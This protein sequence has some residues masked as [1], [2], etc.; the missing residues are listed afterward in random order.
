MRLLIVLLL[1]CLLLYVCWPL[2]IL[3]VVAVPVVW[4]LLLPFRIAKVV[5]EAMVA[6][7]RG[8]LF[9]PARALGVRV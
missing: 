6:L 3:L 5:I 4:L 1:W 9:L 7:L 8:V 2:A